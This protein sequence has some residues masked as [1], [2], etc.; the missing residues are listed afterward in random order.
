MPAQVDCYA[1]PAGGGEMGER[2]RA[3]DWARTPLGPIDSWR[4]SLRTAVDVVLRSPV[5]LVMLWGADGIMIY[6][7][8]Y[9]VFAGGRHPQLLGSKVLEGWPE[10][11]DLNRRVMDVGLR[12]ETLSFRDEHLILF[13]P[14]R[15]P[16]VWVDLDYSPLLDENG[17]PAGVLA[18]VVETTERVLAEKALRASEAQFRT[19]AGAMPHHVWAAKPDGKLDWVNTKV[20]EYTGAKT[21]ALQGDG[22]GQVVHPKDLSLAAEAWQKALASGTVY[23]VEFRLRRSDGVYRWHLA[24]AMPI[25]DDTGQVQRWIGTNTDIDDRIQAER[26][27]RDRQADLA[28][29]QQIGKVGGVEVFLTEGFRNRRSPEYL[30]IHG[31][32]PEAAGE[33]HEDWVRRIHP[34]DRE[35]T[36][37][38]FIDAVKGGVRE[39][40]SEYRIVRPSDGQVRWIAVKAEIERDAQ[41]RPLRLVGAHIDVTDRKLAEEAVRESEQRFRLVSE[42]AP[43]MLWMGDVAGKCLYLNRALREFWG[44]APEEVTGFDWNTSLHPDDTPA[45]YSVFSQA[46]REHT[47]FTIEARYRRHDGEYRLI[48]T[49]AQPR[50]DASGDFLGMI[51]VNI[52]ITEARLAEGS[53]KESE[54]RFRL[55]AN[56]APV[57]MWVSRLDGKRAFV[58]Q[59][60]MDF[61]GFGYEECLV[62]DWRKALHPDDVQ[63]ILGEQIAGEG[64]KK[65]FALEARYRRA[66]GEWRWLRSESQP[67]WGPDEEHIGFIGV[68]HDITAAKQAENELRGLNETL[69][70]QVDARTRERDRVW[71]VSQDILVV[72]DQNGVWLNASPAVTTRL[73]WSQAELVGRSSEWIEHHDDIQ[74]SRA[75]LDHLIAGRITQRF[76]NRLR[77]KDGS[78]R[79]LS[80]TAASHEGRIY[81]TARD[82]TDEKEAAETL[83]RTEEALRQSQKMEAVGQLTGGIAHDFNNLLQGIVGSLDLVQKRLAD[84]RLSEIQRYVSG[85]M[86]SANRAA[87]LTHRLLAF[88]R[89][90]PLDPKSLRANPLIASMED[91]LRRTLGERI[92]LEL[93]LAGDLWPTL[94]DQ[95]QLENS[96]LNLA[97][98][99]RDAMPDGGN[100]TIETSNTRLDAEAVA[101]DRDMAPGEYIRIA[102]TDT[103]TGMTPDV[104]AR[105]FDPFFTTKPTGQGTGLGLSM[106]YGFARQSDGYVKIASEQGKGTTVSL[107]LPR[108]DAVEY[109]VASAE[110]ADAAHHAARG[111]TVLVVEDE[112]LVRLL[113]TDVLEELGYKALEANDGPGGLRILQSPQRIDLLITDIGLPGLNGR[114][115]ADAARVTRPDLKVLFMTGYA[116]NAVASKGI[117]A[118]GMQIITKP[119]AMD[120]FT[121]R[122]RELMEAG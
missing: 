24:R 105:A 38:Q 13:R 42:S 101:S 8:A 79:W 85:A 56:S 116:E 1:F 30:V 93:A 62:Y 108:H 67:R 12:G 28:R 23:E 97:I 31:L 21:T 96:I 92:Q 4:Q 98:N 14:G 32:P 121:Q 82:I 54:E 113:I 29:V 115:I 39:Y 100:L 36:E 104:M 103:G 58:N 2:I 35:E 99:A 68:A 80:W 95:N 26:A 46:M 33:T 6:N 7:D 91:L 102:V 10:V 74:R 5:P 86:T 90:Q 52:D 87:A 48:R 111:Q 89:R 18:I 81:A 20:L 40:N 3:F 60:Y 61:L 118:S 34:E 45:L 19:F 106:I 122:I 50:F 112:P 44:V 49:D 64:S 59:A 17:R 47:P 110:Q 114:Q 53:L 16:D 109:E 117:L 63:R 120:A 72:A 107:Y 83:R 71:N 88:S 41:G 77:H 76:E 43:V 15:P 57:P 78:Y 66:D 11:A 119:F 75:E 27:L 70:A 73:G 9:S 37:R 51:G 25:R 22:W 69:E 84:G 94:C 65:P 55:I